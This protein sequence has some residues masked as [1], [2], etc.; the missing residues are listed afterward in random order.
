MNSDSSARRAGDGPGAASRAGSSASPLWAPHVHADRRPFLLARGRIL[1][2]WRRWSEA[3]GFAEVDTAILQVAPGADLHTS[4]FATTLVGPDGRA[5]PR[6]LHASPEYSCK[7]LLA[8]GEQRIFTLARVFRNRDRGPLHHPEFTMLEWYR[9]GEPY[10]RL[11]EDCQTIAALAARA[12]GASLLQWRGATC[13]PAAPV[14]RLTVT[15][16]FARHAGV[17]LDAAIAG[18]R[19]AFARQAE[20]VGVGVRPDDG[21][22]DIFSKIVSARI[23]P[24]LGLGRLTALDRYPASEAALARLCAD[25]P[26]FAERFELYACGVELANAFGELTD[27]HEQRR[28]FLCEQEERSR[29]YGEA[30]PLDE[31]LLDA[32]AHMPAASGAALGADRLIA[33][34]C[35][36]PSIEHVMWTPVAG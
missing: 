15:E 10:E 35:G 4:A 36:A 33:L 9:A 5:Q 13:D 22:S 3:E 6:Y 23:E 30:H 26:R 1:S 32:L 31:D 12:A 25:N 17:D 2:A 29:L 20:A 7:K 18:G 11:I 24:N 21:W 27:P 8:A 34:A 16:A 28:R 14:E 19:E